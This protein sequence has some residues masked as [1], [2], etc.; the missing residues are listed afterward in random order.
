[1]KC[2]ECQS[3]LNDGD[4]FCSSCGKEVLKEEFYEF[5]PKCGSKNPI[6]NFC[7]QCG[8]N[9]IKILND[10]NVNIVGDKY[11]N[12]DENLNS[13]EAND[14]RNNE[15][16]ISLWEKSITK[17]YINFSGRSS[18]RE[19]GAFL[20]FSTLFYIFFLALDLGMI[21]NGI[22]EAGLIP[23][24]PLMSLYTLFMFLPGLSIQ[25]RRLRDG[26]YHP[27]LILINIIPYLGTI[28]LLI[29]LFQKSKPEINGVNK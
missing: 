16:L 25:I 28:I 1:M 12:N 13:I 4:K 17:H 24:T 26:G 10:E 2:T 3:I 8:F 7:N 29:F 23:F 15:S 5:C 18:R 27:A 20:L 21:A 22:F 6:G 11:H 19:F 9:L 14:I